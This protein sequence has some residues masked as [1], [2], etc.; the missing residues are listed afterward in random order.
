MSVI[1][2]YSGS[3]LQYFSE[4]KL[5]L[6]VAH[7]VFVENIKFETRS[8]GRPARR[9]LKTKLYIKIFGKYLR[10]IVCVGIPLL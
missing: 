3:N 7:H 10:Q 9:A 8:Y 4:K 2:S 5:F 6:D 1:D